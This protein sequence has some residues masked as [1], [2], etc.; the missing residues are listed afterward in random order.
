MAKGETIWSTKYSNVALEC[1]IG[2]KY[3]LFI[4][5]KINDWIQINVDEG[6]SPTQNFK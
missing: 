1:K 5:I 6:K 4:Q 2:I 3:P